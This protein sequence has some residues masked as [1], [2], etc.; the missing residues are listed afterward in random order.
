MDPREWT[1]T[2][3]HFG[4]TLDLFGLL[5]GFR[6]VSGIGVELETEDVVEGGQNQYVHKLPG[7]LRW[8]NLEFERGVVF[9]DTLYAWLQSCSGNNLADLGNMVVRGAGAIT[10]FTADGIPLRMWTFSGALP[11]SWNGPDFD[12][13]SDEVATEKLVVAHDG[14]VRAF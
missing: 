9:V 1:V 11:V 2:T 12:A 13:D 14:I 5:G 4:V 8:Q 6:K 10:M 7:R 3:S